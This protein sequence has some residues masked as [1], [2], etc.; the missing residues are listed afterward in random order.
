MRRRK[1]KRN[2]KKGTVKREQERG[3]RERKEE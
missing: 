3:N 1:R 2:M